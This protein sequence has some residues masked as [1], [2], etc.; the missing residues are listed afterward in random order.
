M[1]ET[2]AQFPAWV[3][4]A[5]GLCGICVVLSFWAIR[6]A[7]MSDFPGESEKMFWLL[8]IMFMPFI[9]VLAYLTVGRTRAR[10]Q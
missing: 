8:A 2:L 6:H 7:Y 5:I 10:R 4:Y 1:I 3:H 9:G